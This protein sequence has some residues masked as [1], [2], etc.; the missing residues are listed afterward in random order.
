MTE[1]TGSF[2]FGDGPP[3]SEGD[4]D[5]VRNRKAVLVVGAVAG[6]LVLGAAGW[7]L[8]S[9]GS[10]STTTSAAAPLTRTVPTGPRASATPTAPA[11]V[12]AQYVGQLG[13]DPF[14]A[15]YVQPAPVASPVPA[16]AP[17]AG[18]VP[19]AVPAQPPAQPPAVEH[20]LVLQ[21]VYGS[22][23]DQTAAFTIDGKNSDA[24]IGSTFGPTA[25]IVLRALRQGPK[26]GPWTATLQV[27]DGSPFEVVT[28]VPAYV[29]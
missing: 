4:T 6:L 8:F 10:G 13:R 21:R 3:S 25:E 29:R 11:V 7:F 19:G 5:E 9:P 15:L 23:S 12:P 17:A 18:T 20:K 27:G 22:G 1:R 14:R 24:R 2:P 26:G 16:A 28:G